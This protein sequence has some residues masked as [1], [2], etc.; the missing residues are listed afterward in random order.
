[1]EQFDLPEKE[2]NIWLRIRKELAL[3][4]FLFVILLFFVGLHVVYF[5]AIVFMYA[6]LLLLKRNRI[7][8]SLVFDD[9]K[10]ALII[11]FYYFIF[12]QG[13]AKIPYSKLKYKN[14]FKRFGFGAATQTIELLEGNVLVGEIRKDGKWKWPESKMNRILE[15]LSKAK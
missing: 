14:G 7:I 11:H 10:Q 12:L 6:L 4:V 3:L 8:T 15:I 1:M 9:Q 13:I 5:T 2:F